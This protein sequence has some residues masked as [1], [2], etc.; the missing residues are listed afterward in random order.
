M[1]VNVIDPTLQG[2]LITIDAVRTVS[3][4]TKIAV[5]VDKKGHKYCARFRDNRG[6]EFDADE[7][8]SQPPKFGLPETDKKQERIGNPVKVTFPDGQIET[9][10]SVRKAAKVIGIDQK[11]LRRYLGGDPPLKR[12]D[13]KF[14]LVEIH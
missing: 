13:Y 5:I 4:Y 1:L 11:T 3:K 12:K 6:V 9:F 14:E 2:Q 10:L 7:D 8:R